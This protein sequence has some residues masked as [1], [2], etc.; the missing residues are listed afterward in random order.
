MA[1]TG[2]QII[3]QAKSARELIKVTVEENKQCFED[4]YISD[5]S[6]VV[7]LLKQKCGSDPFYIQV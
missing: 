1:S 7:A 5:I 6:K 4:A 3:Q 2:A